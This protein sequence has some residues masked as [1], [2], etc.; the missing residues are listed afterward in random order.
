MGWSSGIKPI[1]IHNRHCSS[2]AAAGDVSR[3]PV[4]IF[5]VVLWVLQRSHTM[6]LSLRL[7]KWA[8]MSRNGTWPL[9]QSQADCRDRE[10][11]PA[12]GVQKFC[13]I[14]EPHPIIIKFNL[15]TPLTSPILNR[16]II[17]KSMQTCNFHR[18]KKG[19]LWTV[20]VSFL[21]ARQWAVH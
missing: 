9:Q 21:L 16:Y 10:T 13:F 14:I 19:K 17:K 15:E 11:P 1:K 8:V 5:V 7:R 2:A 6:L 18:Q 12:A 20:K 3:S 4:Y